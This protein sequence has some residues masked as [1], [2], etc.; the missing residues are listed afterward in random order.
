VG[1]DSGY[2]DVCHVVVPD[3]IVDSM[4]VD[5]MTNKHGKENSPI[6][7]AMTPMHCLKGWCNR[8]W[9]TFDAPRNTIVRWK[10]RRDGAFCSPGN[11][12]ASLSYKLH[13]KIAS[14]HARSST[15]VF[16]KNVPHG[17]ICHSILYYPNCKQATKHETY[18]HLSPL[19]PAPSSRTMHETTQH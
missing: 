10:L 8:V 5:G 11:S 1:L 16:N 6:K 14:G 15:I 9:V 2:C 7:P 17:V 13:M 12:C 3:K 18:S 19:S 4:K